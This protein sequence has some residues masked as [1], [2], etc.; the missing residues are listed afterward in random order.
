[1]MP[2]KTQCKEL[3]DNTTYE[4][5]EIDKVSCFKFTNNI[6]SSKYIFIP[7]SGRCS[8]KL[9]DS[10]LWGYYLSTTIYT[11]GSAAA[12]YLVFSKSGQPR[13]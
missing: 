10:Y 4:W 8:N 5:T 6:D 7:L 12:Y 3:I 2:T 11:S 1:M 9:N 13:L